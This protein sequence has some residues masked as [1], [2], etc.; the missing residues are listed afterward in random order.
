MFKAFQKP[1]PIAFT[2][3][4][5]ADKFRTI[6]KWVAMGGSSATVFLAPLVAFAG[7]VGIGAFLLIDPDEE[8]K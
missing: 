2:S 3:I 1:T 5:R 4:T 8:E 6:A 7:L